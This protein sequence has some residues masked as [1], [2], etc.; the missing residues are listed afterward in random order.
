ME[1]DLSNCF[2]YVKA[3]TFQHVS[4]FLD[5]FEKEL[6]ITILYACETG[7]RALGTLVE[8]SDF[9]IKGFYIA[10]ET[11]YLR[12]VRRVIP[13]YI[14]HHLSIKIGPYEFDLDIELKDIKSYFID[15]IETN[16]LR[17]DWWFKS[18]TIYRNLFTDDVFSKLK[19]YL[20]PA[21]YIFSPDDKSG[22]NTLKKN[23]NKQ[24]TLLNKKILSL[25]ISAIQYL[26]IEIFDNEF[27]CYN[28]FE[29]IEY[30]KMNKERVLLRLTIEEVD[31]LENMFDLISSYYMRK[32]EGRV[33]TTKSIPNNLIL[34]IE[35]ITRKFKPEE[36]RKILNKYKCDFDIEWAEETFDN[37]LYKYN[38]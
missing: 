36:K 32:Q 31:L 11:E 13:N 25:I 26:H 15:K 16:T 12:V 3:N 2:E 38:K 18:K 27:P 14:I 5:K 34:F 37:L 21:V 9:D 10:T 6:N 35:M 17:L 7:S 4:E 29:E 28:I 1:I 19:T 22:V 8:E 20:H 30:I 24:G 23:L 33:S